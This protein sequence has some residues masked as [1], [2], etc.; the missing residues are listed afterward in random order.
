MR[1]R[2]R[3]TTDRFSKIVDVGL[4]EENANKING[5]FRA[6]YSRLTNMG[7]NRTA[8]PIEIVSIFQ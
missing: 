1:M 3:A 2:S 8:P 5:E 6:L 7:S 4:K